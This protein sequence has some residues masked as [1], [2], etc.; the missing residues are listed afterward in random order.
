MYKRQG[1]L[2]Q[3][4]ASGEPY[5]THPLQV[6]TYLADLSMDI[7]TVISAI[8]HDLIEDT[9]ITYKDIKKEFGVEIAN[10]VDG[11]TKLD[12]IQYNSNEE[13]Q[14]DAIRKMV[15]AMSKDIRVLILKLA[16]RLHNIQTIE[17]LADY[18]QEKIANETLYVYAPL[19]HRLGLQNIKHILED[20]SFSLLFKNQN[21]E[22]E[23]LIEKTAPNRDKNINKSL[24]V[25]EN[26][27]SDNSLSAEVIGRPKH[28]Y[29][30]YKKIINN[31]LTFNEIN[32]L[33][34]LRILTDDVKNCYTILGL[35]H[36][37][38]Q[39][40]LGRFKDFISMPK[41]NLYQSLHTTVLTETGCLLYTSPSPR[42]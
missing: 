15:I 5:I 35:I 22:I 9:H 16:D 42:D 18:K 41:F 38:F 17:Y 34:G 1:H 8:L 19:A 40:V 33:V 12:K 23:N 6:A 14:A 4:R 25:I 2:N 3:K 26:L 13:A 10:I 39:P 27:L 31:G 30:I 28:N 11:V 37:N 24:K 20:I 36:A 7:E 32:D 21:S 29:S